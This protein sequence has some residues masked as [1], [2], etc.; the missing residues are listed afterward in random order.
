LKTAGE[1]ENHWTRLAPNLKFLEG[2]ELTARMRLQ[3]APQAC[4][5]HLPQ[6]FPIPFGSMVRRMSLPGSIGLKERFLDRFLAVAR[7]WLGKLKHS[8]NGFF[9]RVGGWFFGV[10]CRGDVATKRAG[11]ASSETSRLRASVSF[12]VVRVAFWWEGTGRGKSDFVFDGRSPRL[13]GRRR[14][15]EAAGRD[16]PH[17]LVPRSS[18]FE[19][20][21]FHRRVEAADL[22]S[23]IAR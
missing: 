4:R 5:Y 13:G 11:P 3:N 23:H 18:R 6:F 7:L 22:G 17:W 1:A 8:F 21:L 16:N 15:V 20:F 14:D 2:K 19:A 9:Q 10:C 12:C